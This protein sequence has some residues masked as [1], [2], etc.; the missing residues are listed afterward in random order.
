MLFSYS[1]VFIITIA[2]SSTVIYSIV[3][4]TIKSNIESELKNTSTTILNMVQTSISVSIK[5]HLRAVAEKNLEMVQHV[6]SLFQNGEMSEPEAKAMAKGLLLSQRIGTTGYIACVDS[7]GTML[8]HPR[9]EHV[10]V[11][12]PTANSSRR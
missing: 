8:I 2:I 1:A 12:F 5:N 11:D 3:R 10:G 4:N 6:Y 7:K 9:K